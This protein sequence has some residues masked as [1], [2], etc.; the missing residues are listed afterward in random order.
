[1]RINHFPVLV[2]QSEFLN[3]RI[4]GLKISDIYTQEKNKLVLELNGGSYLEFSIE[5]NYEYLILREG[6]KK[7][8]KNVV[9]LFEEI[10][11][12]EIKT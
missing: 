10:Y 11:N 12:E 3:Q 1:M 5:K 2:L 7:S 4:T 8:N 9:S 6:I